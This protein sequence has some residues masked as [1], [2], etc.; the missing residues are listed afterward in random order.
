MADPIPFDYPG[1][2]GRRLALRPMGL[3]T[4]AAV[5]VDGVAAP[6]KGRTFTLTDNAGTPV[7]M[8][9]K[10]FID[11]IPQIQAGERT[12]TLARPFA[13]Y[14]YVWILLPLALLIVGGFLGGLCGGVAAYVNAQVLRS[15]Y[16]AVVRYGLSLLVILAAAALWL[17]LVILISGAL[18]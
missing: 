14:E 12:I 18:H 5:V 16:P 2:E 11:P 10:G 13:W 9:L 1:F 17:G 15:S 6:R 3:M 7:A 8:R 4:G